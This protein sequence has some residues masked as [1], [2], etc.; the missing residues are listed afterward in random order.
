MWVNPSILR[1]FFPWILWKG[2]PKKKTVFL[3]F[4]DGPHPQHTLKLL[5]ILK[6]EKILATF[7]L[8]GKNALQYPGLVESIAREGHDIGNHGFSHARMDFRN[9]QWIRSEIEKTNHIIFSIT[10]KPPLFFRPPYGRFDLRFHKL[11]K[12]TNQTLVLWSLLTG[13]FEESLSQC[14]IERVQKHLHPGAILV[15]HDGHPNAPV[16]LEAFEKIVTLIRKLDFS[17]QKLSEIVH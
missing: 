8:T 4:D 2:D 15:F 3:T 1:I 13:D 16:M 5:D 9:M 10:G 11:M 6:T 12:E 7:F 14:L 17:F